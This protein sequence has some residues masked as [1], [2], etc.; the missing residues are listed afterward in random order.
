MTTS[1]PVASEGI[2]RSGGLG[3]IHR[4]RPPLSMFM[5]NMI[6]FYAYYLLFMHFIEDLYD[7]KYDDSHVAWFFTVTIW[8]HTHLL[9][10]CQT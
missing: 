6:V 8:I 10:G 4:R 3:A 7:D 2:L 1:D 5:P 9:R